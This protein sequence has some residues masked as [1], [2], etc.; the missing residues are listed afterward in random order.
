[1]NTMNKAVNDKKEADPRFLERDELER[2]LVRRDKQALISDAL[3]IFD[4]NTILFEKN[5]A[6]R[7]ELDVIDK[8]KTALVVEVERLKARKFWAILNERIQ[9]RIDKIRQ[10]RTQTNYPTP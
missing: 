5:I 8:D 7:H 6:Y 9:W 2:D 10:R 4:S 1:M 3:K